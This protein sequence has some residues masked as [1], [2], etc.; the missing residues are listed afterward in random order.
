MEATEPMDGPSVLRWTELHAVAR[1]LDRVQS[2][3]VGTMPGVQLSVDHLLR[4]HWT[5][6]TPTG[7]VTLLGGG[8]VAGLV[9]PV[10]LPLRAILWALEL[11]RVDDALGLRIRDGGG[12]P[13]VE[14][15][16]PR[17]SALMDL[18]ARPAVEVVAAE[19]LPGA[20]VSAVVD[21]RDLEA[22]LLAAGRGTGHPVHAR[23]R[24]P[25][26]LSID[27][28]S[29]TIGADW[30]NHGGGRATYRIVADVSG[31]TEGR[32]ST[33]VDCELMFAIVGGIAEEC[34]EV[35]VR[36]D[37]SVCVVDGE[38][39]RAVLTPLRTP[40]PRPLSIEAALASLNPVVT[41]AGLVVR[42][43]ATSVLVSA[44]V[45]RPD[46]WRITTEL[47]RGVEPQ[48][49][50]L[51]E[52]N[53]LNMGIGFGRIALDGDVLVA[54]TEVRGDQ[55]DALADTVIGLAREAAAIG[56]LVGSLVAHGD[57]A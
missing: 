32:W 39:V 46:L 43:G 33:C 38:W 5:V 44:P 25:F 18:P 3:E 9:R 10:W 1:L 34:V 4:R 23:D 51:T 37:G 40:V 17:G 19:R 13:S 12:A 22:L 20:A 55:L 26:G 7:R 45:G 52:L 50:V 56:P 54:V 57:S 27:P 28:D 41:P 31:D 8:G 49:D 35:S 2:D 24:A 47:A 53:Q 6:S 48:V 21:R 16:A 29:L 14:L 36:A 11:A 42:R 30:S 15:S